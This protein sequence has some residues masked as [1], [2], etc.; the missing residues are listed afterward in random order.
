LKK[1]EN[2]ES[3]ATDLKTLRRDCDNEKGRSK[4]KDKVNKKNRKIFET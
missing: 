1:N 2:L 4:G 3:D